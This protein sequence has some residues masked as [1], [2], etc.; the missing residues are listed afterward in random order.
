[1]V[2]MRRK[3]KVNQCKTCHHYWKNHL[4][5]VL[6]ARCHGRVLGQTWRVDVHCRPSLTIH[7]LVSLV[8]WTRQDRTL[9]LQSLQGRANKLC[10]WENLGRRKWPTPV[11]LPGESCG[12]RSLAG[13]SPW[14]RKRRT[15]LSNSTTTTRS[16]CVICIHTRTVFHNYSNY[17]R[18]DSVCPRVLLEQNLVWGR[19]L[20]SLFRFHMLML[21][22]Q[23][24]KMTQFTYSESAVKRPIIQSL[25][26]KGKGPHR[27]FYIHSFLLIQAP[28]GEFLNIMGI[29]KSILVLKKKQDE[30]E[31]K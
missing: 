26:T 23:I 12:Q 28:G 9:S 11:L 20:E 8:G 18:S 5:H 22:E 31:K 3:G 14:G 7:W 15:R 25:I 10:L 2:F 4:K 17:R 13:F 27:H 24:S 1:M 21:R 30:Q 19:F 16:L 6:T 29:F